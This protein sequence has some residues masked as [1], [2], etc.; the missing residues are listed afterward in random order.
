MN[1]L[2]KAALIS[3]TMVSLSVTAA[4]QTDKGHNFRPLSENGINI[5]ASRVYKGQKIIGQMKARVRDVDNGYLEHLDFYNAMSKCATFDDKITSYTPTS[6]FDTSYKMSSFRKEK[7]KGAPDSCNLE[8]QVITNTTDFTISCK[9]TMIEANAIS[10]EGIVSF[11][12]AITRF[13]NDGLY[14][15]ISASATFTKLQQSES[16]SMRIAAS[17]F[18]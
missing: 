2:L 6:K 9:L 18:E 17:S 13:R 7:G 8:T 15:N 16:C 14:G 1:I 12:K 4:S 11:S 5:V 10:K 3:S